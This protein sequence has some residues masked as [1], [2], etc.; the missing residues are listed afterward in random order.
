MRR[1]FD[2]YDEKLDKD[3][4]RGE[5]EIWGAVEGRGASSEHEMVAIRATPAAF[6]GLMR[7][8][9]GPSTGPMRRARFARLQLEQGYGGC[10]DAGHRANLLAASMI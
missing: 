5:F 8:L 10:C 9:L 2:R 1:T 3:S 4:G 7:R 6:G